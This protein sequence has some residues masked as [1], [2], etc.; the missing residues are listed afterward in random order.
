M[1]TMNIKRI[2]IAI[3]AMAL[4]ACAGQ[5]GTSQK[6]RSQAATVQAVVE[7]VAPVAAKPIKQ[8]QT[9]TNNTWSSPAV[10]PTVRPVAIRPRVSASD[11]V[12]IIPLNRSA[13]R[14]VAITAVSSVSPVAITPLSPVAQLMTQ[15]GEHHRT[16]WHSATSSYSYYIGGILSADYSPSKEELII[17]SDDQQLTCR[18]NG[19]GRLIDSDNEVTTRRKCDIL[20]SLL[21]EHLS[22]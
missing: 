20:V 3:L 12:E 22:N 4:S 6:H 1:I 9:I 17:S 5:S 19:K 16:L 10:T 18:Y 13:A 11:T 7:V 14:P 2:T 21:T 15:I 8:P